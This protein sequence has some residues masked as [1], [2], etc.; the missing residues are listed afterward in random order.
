METIILKEFFDVNTL[1]SLDG[2]G[3]LQQ[4]CQLIWEYNNEQVDIRKTDSLVML[5]KKYYDQADYTSVKFINS[6]L[7]CIDMYEKNDS[8]HHFPDMFQIEHTDICNA[9]C[10]MCNHSFTRNHSC[11]FMDMTVIRKLEKYFPYVSCIV[12]NGIGEPLLHPEI[13]ELMTTYAKYG[14]KL[15][16]NTN[17][18]VMDPELA[19]LMH[20]TFCDIQI[21][22]DAADKETYE[23]IRRGLSFD[24]FKE[25][26]R[27]LRAAGSVEICMAT[28]VMR[29][30][31]T[32]LPQ[33]VE[34]AHELG[35]AK[36]IFLDLNTSQLLQNTNDC[37]RNFPVTACY[38]MDKA[39]EIGERLGVIVHTLDYT[40]NIKKGSMNT[41]VDAL[42]SEP[43]FYP[44]NLYNDIYNMYEKIGFI[45][46]I[47]NAIETDYCTASQ[48][49]SIGYCQFVENRP[50]I[51]ADGDVFNCC[52]RRMHSMG[53]LFD[54]SFSE[55]WNGTAMKCIRH[56]FNKG[57]LPKYCSGCTYLRSGLMVD[58]I[59]MLEYDES[60]YTDIYDKLR[61]KIIREER[62]KSNE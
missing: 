42:H 7:C 23:K 8:V 13:K 39:K 15:S 22:C 58:R 27:I 32:Q 5:M 31:V 19:R 11:K 57:Y 52:T 60:F 20:D 48:F 59:K 17:M 38:Y 12:L 1:F 6:I 46:P 24:K 28:V 21:S 2:Q 26:T 45:N 35:C 33:I 34:L 30:N 9:K 25:N 10:I 37:A 41:E 4:D 54:K 29:Q 47:F 40:Y 51:S 44:E 3:A 53:N 55:V 14:I 16:T 36:V 50:F 56:I 43:M 61:L 49:R 62:E 18:S